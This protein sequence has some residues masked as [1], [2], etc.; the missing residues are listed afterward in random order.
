MAAVVFFCGLILL[1]LGMIG[2]YLGRVYISM[3]NSPQYVI[4]ESIDERNKNEG[5]DES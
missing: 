5:N 3:N 2:E 4:R 1:M